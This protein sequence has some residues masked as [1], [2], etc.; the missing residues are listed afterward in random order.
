VGA[1]ISRRQFVVGTGAA[2]FGLLTG[3]GRLPWQSQ[4]TARVP[5]IGLISPNATYFPSI[6]AF[7]QWLRDHGY[8][9]GQTI[10]ID[11]R[12]YEPTPQKESLI[13]DQVAELVRLPLDALVV[14]G[15]DAIR[16]A[17]QTATGMPLILLAS[18]TGAKRLELL[19]EAFPWISRVAILWNAANVT[20]TG[21]WQ[22]VELAA[23]PLGVQLQSLAVSSPEALDPV[24][25]AAIQGHA[26]GLV[27]LG[28][29]AAAS[30]RSQRSDPGEA[31]P[32]LRSSAPAAGHLPYIRVWE[33]GRPDG[34]WA[35]RCRSI[36][37]RRKPR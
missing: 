26:E 29:P 8:V 19:V 22:E 20:S 3:C 9:E 32:E 14:H 10:T 2:S 7:R 31:N 35:R 16:A 37:P 36:R 18:N 13:A 30:E 4:P 6:Q 27:V 28:D 25:D 24:F 5:R 33:R 17:Q 34:Q 21:L 1:R 23:G 12:E 15:T 11:Y